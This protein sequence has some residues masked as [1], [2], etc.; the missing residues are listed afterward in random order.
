MT[1]DFAT[2]ELVIILLLVAAQARDAYM[3]SDRAEEIRSAT[4][5]GMRKGFDVHAQ[6][7][8]QAQT[9]I[10]EMYERAYADLHARHPCTKERADA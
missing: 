5:E 8:E 9:G 4:M 2:I 3:K 1:F 6:L 7:T 10:A